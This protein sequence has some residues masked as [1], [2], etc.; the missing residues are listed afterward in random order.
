VSAGQRD[1]ATEVA[2]QLQ[3][4]RMATIEDLGPIPTLWFAAAPLWT[5]SAAEAARFPKPVSGFIE[6]AV[7]AGWCKTR[8]RADPYFWITDDARR[9]V[10]D[11]LRTLL[12]TGKF[13]KE[14]A[15]IA[16]AIIDVGKRRRTR[17]PPQPT[18]PGALRAWA[19]LITSAE[20]A[21][22]PAI[23]VER[24]A[25]AVAD[26]DADHV[27]E[28]IAACEALTPLVGGTAVPLTAPA[29]S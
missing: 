26:Y 22:V 27:Q 13:Q 15:K 20:P 10:T 18:V 2:E 12:Q 9:D 6:R 16:Q 1:V 25:K 28:L 17:R 21:G 23:L 4:E 5:R 14:L 8:G 7:D 3:A 29:G 11:D 24:A 19:E